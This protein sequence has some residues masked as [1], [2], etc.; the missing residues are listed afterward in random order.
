[1]GQTDIIT[2]LLESGA[3][4][5]VT[6]D[7]SPESRPRSGIFVL[8][9]TDE[10]F[11]KAKSNSQIA[12]LYKQWRA[13]KAGETSNFEADIASQEAHLEV[14]EMSKLGEGWVVYVT[15]DADLPSASGGF[16]VDFITGEEAVAAGYPGA[17]ADGRIH[18][19]V[20]ISRLDLTAIQDAINS[21]TL[22][23]DNG[24]P[25]SIP[26]PVDIGNGNGSGS[27]S[28][29]G[30][31]IEPPPGSGT[32]GT[33][34]PDNLD[35]IVRL[36]EDCTYFI[37]NSGPCAGSFSYDHA[38]IRGAIED[39]AA[40]TG[41][42]DPSNE[43]LVSVQ[44]K[45]VG[46]A[47]GGVEVTV[48]TGEEPYTG[49]GGSITGPLTITDAAGDTIDLSYVT[50]KFGI[51]GVLEVFGYHYR[52]RNNL[53]ML[54]AGLSIELTGEVPTYPTLGAAACYT[55]PRETDPAYLK[56]CLVA[57][58]KRPGV[59]EC[60]KPSPHTNPIDTEEDV[61]ITDCLK[62]NDPAGSL[63]DYPYGVGP[64]WRGTVPPL[65]Q[66]YHPTK[67]TTGVDFTIHVGVDPFDPDTGTDVY[68]RAQNIDIFTAAP[69]YVDV[70]VHI[71]GDH[72]ATNWENIPASGHID[73]PVN[74]PARSVCQLFSITAVDVNDV[75][76]T[77][78]EAP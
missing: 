32:G 22:K 19:R 1:M 77:L 5:N 16:D 17:T 76:I 46:A 33:P 4:V 52:G 44:I 24:N 70:A 13:Y 66:V 7:A 2:Y 42:F 43:V 73:F 63:L 38:N 34:N 26:E 60:W 65:F 25:I 35:R 15:D 78:V 12:L 9:L 8:Q 50:E 29:T 61:E 21:H 68:F 48:D 75:S 53:K 55:P 27:G 47:Y 28:G 18:P 62:G 69:H 64:I 72:T 36:P 31:T 11:R 10:G 39:A 20:F 14:S 30:G 6:E 41:H 74:L 57:F 49:S 56:M 3:D 59:P 23:D 45:Y 67:E 58:V 54:P 40:T 71:T 51:P 37:I